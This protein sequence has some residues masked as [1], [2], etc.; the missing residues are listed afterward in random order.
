M[1]DED[2]KAAPQ[3]EPQTLDHT[4]PHS[5]N[6][7]PGS[8]VHPDIPLEAVEPPPEVEPPPPEE[9]LS[10]E[11]PPDPEAAQTQHR[12]TQTQTLPHRRSASH[13]KR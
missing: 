7:P 10:E 4:K 8:D 5:P 13:S 11:P 2:E 6:E 9:P 1:A 3:P 12:G